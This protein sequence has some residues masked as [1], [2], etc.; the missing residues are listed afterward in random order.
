MDAP[1][2]YKQTLTKCIEIRLDG[3][4]TRMLCALLNKYW[5]LHFEKP[6]LHSH[7]LPISQTIK[8]SGAGNFRRRKDELI[9]V[10]S[11]GLCEKKDVCTSG[12]RGHSMQPR[13]PARA[14]GDTEEQW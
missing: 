6:Q 11:N 10:S 3:N 9:E 4:C 12:L 7:L 2:D 14:D 8:V 1:S 5:R 13:G